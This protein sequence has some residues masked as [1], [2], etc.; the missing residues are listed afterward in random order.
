MASGTR[1]SS[2]VRLGWVVH[3]WHR[4]LF[5]Y[6]DAKYA[7]VS[8]GQ[9]LDGMEPVDLR[10]GSA[11]VG[12]G[13]R[14][15]LAL[16]LTGIGT[17]RTRRISALLLDRAPPPSGQWAIGETHVDGT[18]DLIHL[19]L[20]SYACHQR[21]CALPTGALEQNARAP[22]SARS[23]T[24]NDGNLG[25]PGVHNLGLQRAMAADLCRIWSAACQMAVHCVRTQP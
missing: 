14:L 17:A 5:A 12:R 16:D 24:C 2:V 7:Y 1:P 18:G 10:R 6:Q 4:L 9:R 22:T 3:P 13:D 25:C 15:A 19:C 11:L 21:H 8:S 23:S 20:P